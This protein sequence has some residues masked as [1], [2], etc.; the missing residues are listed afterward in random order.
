VVLSTDMLWTEYQYRDVV[1][2]G[3]LF[4]TSY[5]DEF[6][7]VILTGLVFRLLLNAD[8]K[9]AKIPDLSLECRGAEVQRE[10]RRR[11]VAESGLRPFVKT[12]N[13]LIAASLYWKEPGHVVGG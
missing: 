8:P 5:M 13:R 6:V 1:S 11:I 2:N 9:H 3:L 12:R 7:C 4:L 10:E